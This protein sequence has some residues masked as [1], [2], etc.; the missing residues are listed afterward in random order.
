MSD[1]AANGDT[2]SLFEATVA[3]NVANDWFLV[4]SV[5]PTERGAEQY[6]HPAGLPE[7]FVVLIAGGRGGILSEGD[8]NAERHRALLERIA[9][10]EPWVR[11]PVLLPARVST[12]GGLLPSV[13]VDMSREEACDIAHAFGQSHVL[14]FEPGR[15]LLVPTGDG[16]TS[17]A[18]GTRIRR[19]EAGAL[20]A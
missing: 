11:P 7:R 18:E 10:T 17:V 8:E 19:A 9:T 12:P 4:E 2:A 16:E 1:T 13:A 15:R 14:A 3:V 20:D 6:E 5:G